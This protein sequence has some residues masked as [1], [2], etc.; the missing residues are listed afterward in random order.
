[1]AKK[2]APEVAAEQ[3]SLENFLNVPSIPLSELYENIDG[4]TPYS[5]ENVPDKIKK[6]RSELIG[7]IVS[8]PPELLLDF[9][10]SELSE[11]T[12]LQVKTKVQVS[13]E[14]TTGIAIESKDALT[15]FDRE[16]LDAVATLASTMQIISASTIY[17]IITGKDPSFN[18][19]AAQRKK[20]DESMLRCSRCLVNIDMTDSYLA[21]Y[22]SEKKDLESFKFRGQLITY[23]SFLRKAKNGGN[24]YYQ[25]FEMPPIFRYAEMLGKVSQ[26]PLAL[27]DTPVTK[28]DNI[29]TT[30]SY[31]LRAIDEIKKSES[32]SGAILWDDVYA[33]A[34][35][36]MSV[37]QY[38]ANIRSSCKKMLDYWIEQ[39]FIKSYTASA[40]VG[41]KIEIYCS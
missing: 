5:Q 19:G 25:L 12:D 15:N 31:L 17:R 29:I 35:I 21:L 24:I 27:L 40:A 32:L 8:A 4:E 7:E 22:P 9:E 28:K 1:M 39:D 10:Q 14:G 38:R 26:F 6:N 37:K 20:I 33:V 16:V 34:D 13:F 11:V 41:G 36:D 23:K 3:L 2:K 18:V 30:Q